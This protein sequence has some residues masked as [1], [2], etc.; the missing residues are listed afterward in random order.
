MKT[1]ALYARVSTDE[2]ALKHSIDAQLDQLR[3]YVKA[4][5]LQI[6]KEYVDSGYSGTLVQRPEYQ[7]LIN[8][9]IDGKFEAIVV[10]KVDRLFRSVRHLLNLVHELETY[11]VSVCSATEP[12]DSGTPVGRFTLQL[13]GSVAELERGIFLQRSKMGRIKRLEKGLVWAGQIPYGYTYNRAN[14]KFEIC[15]Q[16][17]EV[18]RL[19]FDLYCGVDMSLA[20]V[21]DELNKRGYK[22]RR[23]K[24]WRSDSVLGVLRRP[25][26]MGKHP[27]NKLTN[28]SKIKDEKEWI[29][30]DVPAIVS[31]SIYDRAQ[32]LLD[33]RRQ[34]RPGIRYNFLLNGKMRCGYCNSPMRGVVSDRVAKLASGRRKYYQYL[35][36]RCISSFAAREMTLKGAKDPAKISCRMRQ[37]R[38]EEIETIIGDQITELLANPKLIL[39]AANRK[40]VDSNSRD[41]NKEI[42]DINRK[43]DD[44][45]RKNQS[46]ITLYREGI[47][48]KA[49]LMIQLEDIRR[50]KE[51]LKEKRNELDKLVEAQEQDEIAVI[52]LVELCNKVR[53]T[54]SNLDIAKRREIVDLIIEKIVITVDGFIEMHLALPAH[55]GKGLRLAPVTLI[56]NK[57]TKDKSYS[58]PKH[59]NGKMIPLGGG[60]P[61]EMFA[62]I[63]Q[64][65]R[66]NKVNTTQMIRKMV[67]FVAQHGP[68]EIDESRISIWKKEGLRNVY[69]Y[70]RKSINFTSDQA[71]YLKQVASLLNLSIAEIIRLCVIKYCKAYKVD[72]GM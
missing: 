63:Q 49:D 24:I 25:A 1:V 43:I 44:T 42:E 23:L 36:Y 71:H 68:I 4:H 35:Y 9:A 11:G 47:I 19:M 62:A 51:I 15:E 53:D 8:D 38:A 46:V 6:Y 65:A 37:V 30:V 14:G 60:F 59:Q 21:A 39:D 29:W 17:A 40:R 34:C 54:V 13:F 26:Y 31:K 22:T 27:Y 33:K 48:S 67:S 70:K 64:I 69:T 57:P 32:E 52:S 55:V 3:D 61:Q 50:Q 45:D 12:F 72:I 5:N 58:M 2:Q 28:K 10:Y 18:V 20:K 41:I 7:K 56:R 16:E 66:Q